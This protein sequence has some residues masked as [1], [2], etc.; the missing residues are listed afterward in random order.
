MDESML[1]LEVA[2]DFS[3]AAI[4]RCGNLLLDEE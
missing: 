3:L 1:N 4:E 2:W